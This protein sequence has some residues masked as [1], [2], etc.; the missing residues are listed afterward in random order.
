MRR[1]DNVYVK[2]DSLYPTPDS[3]QFIAPYRFVEDDRPKN[4]NDR[5]AKVGLRPIEAYIFP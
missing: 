5:R 1:N 4:V 2:L 3:F